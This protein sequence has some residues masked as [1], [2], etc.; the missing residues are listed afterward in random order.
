M[1]VKSKRKLAFLISE[2]VRYLK[3]VSVINPKLNLFSNL[4]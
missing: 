2:L 4:N 3:I 1:A